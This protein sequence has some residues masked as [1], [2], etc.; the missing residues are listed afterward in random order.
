MGAV[1]YKDTMYSGGGGMI[2]GGG[3][4]SVSS[5][6][7][8]ASYAGRYSPANNG[9]YSS[10]AV[11]TFTPSTTTVTSQTGSGVGTIKQ[12]GTTNFTTLDVSGYV[13]NL[14]N[15]SDGLLNTYFSDAQKAEMT[16]PERSLI[17]Q[18]EALQKV[19]E[20]QGKKK[21][22]VETKT[23]EIADGVRYE[24]GDPLPSVLSK[25]AKSLTEAINALTNAFTDQFTLL[26]NYMMANLIYQQQF[27]DIK[28]E[29][30]GLKIESMEYNK[31]TKPV[32]DLDG[33]QLGEAAPRE[34][35]FQKDAVVGIEKT[36][37]NN[38]ELD[39]EDIDIVTPF[40]ISS[41]Y[42][43]ERNSVIYENIIKGLGGSV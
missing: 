14:T 22:E 6:A 30:S 8:N 36:D 37:I 23:K 43:Y 16:S 41:I 26:N 42:G 13:K 27:L 33:N 32:Y 24:Q 1:N 12:Y 29:E 39:S 34:V 28:T 19:A 4:G 35:K 21:E 5:S 11:K 3:G 2:M 15:A 17:E 25:N 31:T 38:F 18:Y 20:D 7:N 40:D 9:S 10:G